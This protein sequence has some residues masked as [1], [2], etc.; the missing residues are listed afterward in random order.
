MWSRTQ[1]THPNPPSPEPPPPSFLR[2]RNRIQQK[3]TKKISANVCPYFGPKCCK[4][5]CFQQFCEALRSVLSNFEIAVII[6]CCVVAVQNCSP[7]SIPF[8]QKQL[9]FC[10]I[11]LVFCQHF[12]KI[13]YSLFSSC[14]LDIPL[15]LIWNRVSSFFAQ[16][17]VTRNILPCKLNFLHSFSAA[18]NHKQTNDLDRS[19]ALTIAFH[20]S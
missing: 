7:C 18:G 11:H 5:L 8:F 20:Q 12:P 9:C 14:D 1:C 6:C 3:H 4:F 19:A 2:K 17:A 13:C 16:N 15:G 10:D